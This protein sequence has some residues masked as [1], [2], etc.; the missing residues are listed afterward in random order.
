MLS[1][2]A[3]MIEVVVGEE[4][5]LTKFPDESTKNFNPSGFFVGILD[6]LVEGKILLLNF[7]S[8]SLKLDRSGRTKFEK[9]E[10]IVEKMIC[11]SLTR[12]R[13]T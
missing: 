11:S 2:A 1:I 6:K 8:G 4:G 10:G 13:I 5:R 12:A 9:L 7:V 3:G